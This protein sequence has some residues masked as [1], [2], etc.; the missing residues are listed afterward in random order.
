ME[1]KRGGIPGS[2]NQAKRSRNA[3]EKGRRSAKLASTQK[4]QRSTEVLGPSQLLQKVYKGFC[5]NSGITNGHLLFV[6]GALI[7]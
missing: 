4:Y 2:S 3:E 6:M 5:Q 1:S 7:L